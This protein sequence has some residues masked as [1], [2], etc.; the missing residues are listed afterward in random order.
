MASTWSNVGAVSVY[1]GA[2]PTAAFTYPAGLAL[3]DVIT[4]AFVQRGGASSAITTP[5]GWSHI[6]RTDNANSVSL[7][8]FTKRSD[9]TETGTQNFTVTNGQDIEAVMFARRSST[10]TPATP[11]DVSSGATVS[12]TTAM[13]CATVTTTSADDDVLSIVCARINS[14]T[15]VT[16]TPDAAT[17][18]LTD[19]KRAGTP[20]PGISIEVA[21]ETVA[22]IGATTGRTATASTTITDGACQTIAYKATGVTQSQAPRTLHQFRL[23]SH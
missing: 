15:N 13:A 3:G 10:G 20:N 4:V 6:R 8:T 17:T 14:A 22:A 19:Q 2:G 1:D 16:Y 18:E 23:R 11:L 5:S 9:G 7:D 21:Y 12:G